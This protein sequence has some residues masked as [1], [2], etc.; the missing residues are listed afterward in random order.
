MDRS[1]GLKDLVGGFPPNYVMAEIG[2]FK[3]ES[4][5]VFAKGAK[6]VLCIDP[7][8]PYPE[9][10]LED[11]T[12]AESCFDKVAKEFPSIVKLK[13]FSH[14]RCEGIADASLDVVYVDG[15][16]DYYNVYEDLVRWL[17]KIK[18]G[19]IISGHDWGIPY[20]V[21]AITDVIGEPHK[22]YEDASWAKR[23]PEDPEE[24]RMVVEPL[25]NIK[26]NP[27]NKISIL[28][29]TKFTPDYL[30]DMLFLGLHSLGCNVVDHVL[31]RDDSGFNKDLLHGKP[32]DR[33][34]EP[35]FHSFNISFNTLAKQHPDYLIVAVFEN[36]SECFQ[37]WFE[38]VKELYQT[39]NFPKVIFIDSTDSPNLFQIPFE[40]LKNCPVF[41]REVFEFFNSSHDIHFAAIPEPFTFIPFSQRKFDISFIA[42]TSNPYRLEVAE[43][44]RNTAES[45]GLNCYVRVEKSP[46]PRAEYLEILSQSR[47]SV[48]VRGAGSDCYRYWE[49]SAKGIVLL[50]DD[51][52]LVVTNDFTKNHCFKFK[53]LIQLQE[54]MLTIKQ[55]SHET[56]EKMAIN[57]LLHTQNFHTPVERAKQVLGWT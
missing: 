52:G 36:D 12:I 43:M 50:A 35:E 11:M 8:I 28:Y 9:I 39:R 24:Y 51:S 22:F 1:P 48:S 56:L 6:T 54:M 42:T 30:H 33:E 53:D 23:L 31:H 14:E 13:G 20:L 46:I 10:S 37:G 55:T 7:W 2:C 15:A 27:F 25:K 38:K 21:K 44:I 34:G 26:F 3:G 19:G 5:R 4:T 40:P 47:V 16:H 45:L 57:A 41:K 49:I 32:W 18:P 17:P 29:V